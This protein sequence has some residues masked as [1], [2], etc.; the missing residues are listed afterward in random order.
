MQRDIPAA[1][2]AAGLAGASLM[3]GSCGLF[4]RPAKP[5]VAS[6]PAARPAPRPALFERRAEGSEAIWGLRAGLNV[7]ALSCRG[8]GR[9]PVAPAYA[10]ML[11]RH[12]G[13][14]ATAYREEQGRQ[15]LGAFDRQQTRVYNTFAN[16]AS[17]ARFC[18]A[19][20]TVA[21]RANALDST[22]FA[23]AAPHM[24]GELKA[25]LRRP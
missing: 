23:S 25:S 5:A 3:L 6:R 13:L 10:R 2:A 18:Q 16:Q 17:P 1:I 7:A 12:R 4:D 11:T 15:G 20:S 9:Q 22:Q 24:L 8:R 19:A 21:Q 14:L